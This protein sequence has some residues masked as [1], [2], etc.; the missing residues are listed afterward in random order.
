MNTTT[1]NKYTPSINIK[2]DRSKSLNYIPTPNAKQV[3]KQVLNGLSSGLRSHIIVG[4]YGSG[5]SIFLWA[6]AKSLATDKQYFNLPKTVNSEEF[7]VVNIVGEY[8]SL[9]YS[10]AKEFEVKK[11]ADSENVLNAIERE[12][13]AQQKKNKKLLIVLDEFGKFLEFAAKTNPDQELYF[14]QRLAEI[15]NDQD[16]DYL[17]LATLHQ[18][19]SAYGYKLT[20]QQQS[21]WTKVQG[22]FNEITF[23]EPVEQL[24]FLASER[25][26]IEIHDKPKSFNELFN[27]IKRSRC[28]PLR[29]YMTEDI[30]QKL[31]PLDILSAAVMTQALQRYGQNERSLFSFIDSQDHLGPTK[32]T[33]GKYYSIADVYDYLKHSFSI[34]T[35]KYNPH[36]IQWA[37]ISTSL[38][39]AEG[40]FN[41]DNIYSAEALIKVIGLLNIFGSAAMKL[42]NEF[43]VVYAKYSLGIKAPLKTI[44]ALIKNKI[45]RFVNHSQKYV[46]FEGTDLDIEL[47]I[48]EAGNLVEKVGSVAS[49]LEE[50]FDFQI[51]LAKS[52]Y[53]QK[54]TPRFFKYVISDE[55]IELRVSDEIDGFI[56]LIFNKK[57]SLEKL[58]NHAKKEKRPVLYCLYKNTTEIQKLLFDIKKVEKVI[59]NNTDDKVAIRE[60]KSILNYQKRLLNHYVLDSLTKAND[61]VY[62]VD[63]SGECIIRSE[64]D[65]NQRVSLVSE[66]VYHATPKFSSELINKSKISGSIRSAQKEFIRHMINHY[67]D[68]MW[69]FNP[70]LFPPAKS[71]Y[72]SLVKDKGI[73]KKTS[74]GIYSLQ[75]PRDESFAAL[76][77]VC[78]DFLESTKSGKRS[79]R[80]LVDLLFQ[81]PFKLKYGFTQFW[82]PLFLFIKRND[83]ALYHNDA[84]LP[85]LTAESLEIILK[86]PHQYF[87]KAFQ[88]NG[89]DLELFRYYRRFLQQVE[90]KPSNSSLIETI[91]PFLQLYRELPSYSKQTKRLSKE[92]QN[93]RNAIAKAKDPEALFLQD[94]PSALGMTKKELYGDESKVDLF[95]EKLANATKELRTSFEDLQNRFYN[96]IQESSG[97]DSPKKSLEERYEGLQLALLNPKQRSFY[98]RLISDLEF[99]SWLSSLCQ[100]VL[101]KSLDRIR[102]EEEAKLYLGF[103]SFLEELD[104]LCD[105]SKARL[106]TSNSSDFILID[107][108]NAK[109][110]RFRKVVQLSKTKKDK[111]KSE[112]D[113]ILAVIGKDKSISIAVL[114]EMIKELLD[115]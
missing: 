81:P 67:D 69:G 43:L 36:Y 87:I 86:Y 56:N 11:K 30:G 23:N 42:D 89:V 111:I 32:K 77:Q 94:I 96:H 71:I 108:Q 2:R 70:S 73:V 39:R 63:E 110:G 7:H 22:R 18:N 1:S 107:I 103:T 59:E 44:D 75:M 102:D 3:A 12:Y 14:I 83:F 54:G 95:I 48:D 93:I 19:F 29:D 65:L 82:V 6:I 85:I 79:L 55:I 8:G 97:F 113:A 33:R 49:L 47:A 66:K 38:D 76:W 10:F 17:F 16:K 74:E 37:A 31:L 51:V 78:E 112:K 99:Q 104:N 88:I 28:F 68:S 90:V 91:K 106:E 57:L 20:K 46:L 98:Q 61:N 45:I 115:E 92:G 53:Y 101:G 9:I 58:I 35:T 64:K 13:E 40:Y 24:L 34:I 52:F 15:V 41:G 109:D 105:I 26:G 80:E 100:S 21:E 50:Y 114:A 25:L 5:K 62:W 60:L 27:S 84:Y 4:A 72:Y